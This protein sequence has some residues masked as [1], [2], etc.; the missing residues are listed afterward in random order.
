MN[1]KSPTDIYAIINWFL[2]RSVL[3]YELLTLARLQVYAYFAYGWY[4]AEYDEPL[5]DSSILATQ[6]GIIIPEIIF[7]FRDCGKGLINHRVRIFRNGRDEI[8]ENSIYLSENELSSLT[9]EEQE[10]RKKTEDNIEE[11]LSSVWDSYSKLSDEQLVSHAYRLVAWL[12]IHYDNPHSHN[13]VISPSV[14][15]DFFRHSIKS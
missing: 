10:K 9:A 3:D 13:I 6:Q 4:C 14:I 5:F 8:L 7:A 2:D 12:G 15:R 1:E 11:V